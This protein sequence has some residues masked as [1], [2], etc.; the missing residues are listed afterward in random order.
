MSAPNQP[1]SAAKHARYVPGFHFVTGT[2]N[3]VLLVWSIYRLVTLRD[4]TALF[5]LLVAVALFSHFIYLRQFPLRVQDR[6]IC[7][8]EQ[9]RL[10]RLV[11]AESRGWAGKL[12]ANQLIAL[13][14]ASDEELPSLA[15]RVADER[16]VERRA[17]KGLV[18]Q[19]RPDYM[20]A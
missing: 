13:R 6:L 1:Q 8:E 10:Q 17:I 9:L 19:W 11:P 16:I 15:K 4:S 14:F 12:T 2:L 7:L 18:R 3:L 20:R 5:G